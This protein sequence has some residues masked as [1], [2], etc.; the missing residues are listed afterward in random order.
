MTIWVDKRIAI[1]ALLFALSGCGNDPEASEARLRKGPDGSAPSAFSICKACHS[2]ERG[3][4]IIGPSLH[5]V[6][7]RKAGSL[8]GASYSPAMAGSGLLWDE[9]TLDAFLTSPMV[10]VP[11]TRMTYA[12]Q[13]DPAKRAAIIAYL[14][15]LK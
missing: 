5:G 7:G 3:K 6:F 15:A 13:A 2:V 8:A 1:A 11:G 10:K 9:A 12:G 4:T 14:K